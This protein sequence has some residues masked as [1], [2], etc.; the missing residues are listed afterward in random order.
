MAKPK[1]KKGHLPLQLYKHTIEVMA[2]ANKAYHELVEENRRL[3]I[4]TPFSLLGNI[5]YLM[6][7][8]KIVLKKQLKNA[9]DKE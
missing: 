9:K 6:P 3:G 2:K 1:N 8:G 5:Y 4:P 7:N